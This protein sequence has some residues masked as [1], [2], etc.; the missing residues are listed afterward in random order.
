MLGVFFGGL[1]ALAAMLLLAWALSRARTDQLAQ[2]SRLILGAGALIL[3][4]LLTLRGLGVVGAP[5]A[6]A[7]I[8]LLT[9]LRRKA[10]RGGDGPEADTQRSQRP[11][12]RPAMSEREAR[13]I[14]GVSAD[15]D[16]DAVKAAYREMMKRVHPD[17]GGS[18]ALAAQVR[19]AYE[20]LVGEDA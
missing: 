9:M 16:R 13:E 8:G 17:A 20:T 2:G 1:A 15:A 12:G 4:G 11:R 3:G 18:N 5:L 19:A 7:G 10:G 6:A 14:L